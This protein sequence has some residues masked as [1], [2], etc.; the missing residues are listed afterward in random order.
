MEIF[1]GRQGAG[2]QGLRDPGRKELRRGGG[3]ALS[4]KCFHKFKVVLIIR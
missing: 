1:A 4:A 2:A 3:G